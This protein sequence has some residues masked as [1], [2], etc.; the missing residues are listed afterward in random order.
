[1][2]AGMSNNTIA[3]AESRL[4]DLID[5]ALAGKGIVITREGRP[6]VELR[7]IARAERPMTEIDLEWIRKRRVGGRIPEMDAGTLMS[8]LRDEGER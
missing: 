6:T 7:P 2:I 4:S 8:I 3:E 5:R 1:M